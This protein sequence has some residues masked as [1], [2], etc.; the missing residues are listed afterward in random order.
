MRNIA[1]FEQSLTSLSCFIILFTLEMGNAEIP[2]SIL[3]AIQLTLN[4]GK[5]SAFSHSQLAFPPRSSF[6]LQHD[7]TAT[8]IGSQRR[9]DNERQRR[10]LRIKFHTAESE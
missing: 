2:L 1:S 9:R 8:A 10:S 3:A 6:R 7:S 5:Q 4:G